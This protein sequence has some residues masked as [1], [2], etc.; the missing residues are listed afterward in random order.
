MYKYI[1][2]RKPISILGRKSYLISL[3]ILAQWRYYEVQYT[4]P[5]NICS[6]LGLVPMMG[7]SAGYM[8]SSHTPGIHHIDPVFATLS[9]LRIEDILRDIIEASRHCVTNP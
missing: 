8:I 9:Y 1:L 6:P 5:F 2:Y 3:T 7:A 4:T